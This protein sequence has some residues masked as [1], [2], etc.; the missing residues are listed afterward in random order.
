[1]AEGIIVQQLNVYG[2]LGENQDSTKE[3]SNVNSI[4]LVADIN[5]VIKAFIQ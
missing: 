3:M 1:M 2:V 4:N 5:S